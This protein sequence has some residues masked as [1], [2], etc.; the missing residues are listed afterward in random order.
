MDIG[1]RKRELRER[2]KL[3]PERVR[4]QFL[5]LVEEIGTQCYYCNERGNI[6]TEIIDVGWYDYIA[7]CQSC[8]KY[9]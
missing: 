2:A 6:I 5:N 4:K 8:S 1:R 3:V 9:L 7:C